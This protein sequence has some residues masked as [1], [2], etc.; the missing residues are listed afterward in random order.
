MS[1]LITMPTILLEFRHAGFV[2][3][4]SH[5]YLWRFCVYIDH[6]AYND[7]ELLLACFFVWTFTL[8]FK[9]VLC[10]HWSHISY[11]LYSYN[12]IGT[13]SFLWTFTLIY[14][15]A[16]CLHWSHCLKSCWTPSCMFCLWTFTLLFKKVLFLH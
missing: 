6:T 11:F 5:W 10:L 2:C 16:L 1:T 12:H 13:P 8:L 14:K 9:E 4:H 3:E 7:V 15:E